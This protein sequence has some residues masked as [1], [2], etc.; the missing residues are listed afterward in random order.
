M[1]I[2]FSLIVTTVLLLSQTINEQIHALENASPEKRVELMNHIKE[3]LISMNHEER[4]NTI[5]LLQ[6][7]LQGNHEQNIQEH[8][9]TI[10]ETKEQQPTNENSTEFH[11][12]EQHEIDEQIN[13]SHNKGSTVHQELQ[14]YEELTR[15]SQEQTNL[16]HDIHD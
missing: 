14:Q 8:Q 11:P 2:F 9:D 16:N 5:S 3:Q 7:K 13:V 4:M 1:K 12:L 6:E 15:V 10:E